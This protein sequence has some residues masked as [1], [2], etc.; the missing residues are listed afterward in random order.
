[1]VQFV[2]LPR[3]QSSE[4]LWVNPNH[5]AHVIEMAEPD[6]C[7]VTLINGRTIYVGLSPQSVVHLLEGPNV[8]YVSNKT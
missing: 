2:K 7:D 8:P 6:V 3:Y 5:V 1:M 4:H